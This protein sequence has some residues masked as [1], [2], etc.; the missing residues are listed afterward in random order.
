MPG[1]FEIPLLA[2]SM[3]KSGKYDAVLTIGT[4]VCL[5]YLTCSTQTIY[6]IGVVRV[7]ERTFDIGEGGDHAL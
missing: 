4:V 5:S 2:K 1:S 7:L 3:A 6:E